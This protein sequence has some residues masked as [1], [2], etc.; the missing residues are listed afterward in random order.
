MLP[1]RNPVEERAWIQPM[2]HPPAGNRGVKTVA[3][4]G[5]PLP[6]SLVPADRLEHRD[7]VGIVPGSAHD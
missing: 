3:L 5:E 4:N 6:G 1:T 7:P 2:P